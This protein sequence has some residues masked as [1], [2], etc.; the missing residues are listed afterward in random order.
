MSTRF[1]G[2]YEHLPHLD[3]RLAPRPLRLTRRGRA[4]QTAL[5]LLLLVAF[6]V[7][8]KAGFGF[9]CERWLTESPADYVAAC[10]PLPADVRAGSSWR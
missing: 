10:G 6:F 4:L 8:A 5:L 1:D 7:V 2:P 3:R 9:E